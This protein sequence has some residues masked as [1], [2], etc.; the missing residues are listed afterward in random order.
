[1]RMQSRIG[2]GKIRRLWIV[3]KFYVDYPMLK[4]GY[5]IYTFFHLTKTKRNEGFRKSL[6]VEN[7]NFVM[8][9][10]EVLVFELR[11]CWMLLLIG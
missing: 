1:M 8:W 7:T 2:L 11:N 10:F 6:L 9:L 4:I 3:P 5:A